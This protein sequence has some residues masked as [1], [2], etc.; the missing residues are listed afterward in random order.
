[1]VSLQPSLLQAEQGQLPQAFFIGKVLK[2]SEHLHGPLL[3]PLQQLHTFLVLGS[4]TWTQYSRWGLKRVEQRGDNQS[5]H[6]AGRPS[7]DVTQDIVVK[8]SQSLTSVL[9]K[10]YCTAFTCIWSRRKSVRIINC[11]TIVD[12]NENQYCYFSPQNITG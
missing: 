7:S 6:P 1:M 8:Y 3:D 11:P 12:Q 5:P 2:P 9:N 10:W 4:Q